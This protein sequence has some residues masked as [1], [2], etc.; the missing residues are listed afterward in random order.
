[1]FLIQLV[2]VG[3]FADPGG[4]FMRWSRTWST[5]VGQ[6]VVRLPLFATYLTLLAFG[7]REIWRTVSCP[8]SDSRHPL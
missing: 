1:M 3:A 7:I 4:M 6:T 2:H 5:Q 8:T